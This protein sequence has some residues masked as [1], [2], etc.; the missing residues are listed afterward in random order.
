MDLRSKV[1]S[2]ICQLCYVNNSDVL[3]RRSDHQKCFEL[4]KIRNCISWDI[5]TNIDAKRIIEH[6]CIVYMINNCD[7]DPPNAWKTASLP[8]KYMQYNFPLQN[9]NMAC[10]YYN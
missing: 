7:F 5:D 9:Y 1:L 4:S 10:G 8:L 2:P 6:I 3:L